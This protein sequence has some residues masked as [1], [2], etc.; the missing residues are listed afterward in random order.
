MRIETAREEEDDEEKY[1]ENMR[2]SNKKKEA[3]GQ[4]F[5]FGP[6]A[7]DT[8]QNHNYLNHHFI[9]SLM[10]CR[11]MMTRELNHLRR[12]LFKRKNCL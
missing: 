8:P 3:C 1:R 9:R 12:Y 11:Q 10:F 6:L 5:I 2:K 4:V 7:P